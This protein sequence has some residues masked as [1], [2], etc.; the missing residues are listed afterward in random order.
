MRKGTF[1]KGHQKLGGRQKGTPNRYNRDMMERI[2]RAAEQVGSDGKGKAGVD[3]YLEMLAGKKVGYFVGLLRQAVQRQ[4]PATEPE[5]EIVY[6]T[7]QDFR[8]ALLDRGLHPTLLPPPP[9]DFDERP[10]I[11]GDLKPPKPPPGWQWALIRADESADIEI[12]PVDPEVDNDLT[13]EGGDKTTPLRQE[14]IPP[15]QVCATTEP[16]YGTPWNPAP[17]TSWEY[18]PYTRCWFEKPTTRPT[19]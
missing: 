1:K 7:E 2:L 15:P 5:N 11:N 14:Q 6:A 9:R 4:V 13:A 12:E 3:G 8:Q 16:P 18:N 19:I 10:P 17:G